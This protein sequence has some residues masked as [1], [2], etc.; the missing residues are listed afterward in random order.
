MITWLDA[1]L[2]FEVHPVRPV[3]LVA[4]LALGGGLLLTRRLSCIAIY[5]LGFLWLIVLPHVRWPIGGKAFFVD[6]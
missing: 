2:F 4:F 5:V 6:A 1:V 3:I